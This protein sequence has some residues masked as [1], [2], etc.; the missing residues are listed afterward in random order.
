MSA[1]RTLVGTLLALALLGGCAAVEQALEA[2]KP[3]ASIAGMR[4]VAVDF[5]QAEV[6][7][8]VSIDNP[9]PVGIDLAGFDYALA[10]DGR[11]F[12]SGR[13][14]RALSLPADD[15]TTI[16]VP[17]TIP[18]A[19]I[20]EVVGELRGRD[21]VDYGLELGLDV[22]LPALGERRVRSSTSGSLPIPQRPRVSVAGARVDSLGLSGARLVL[23]LA[24]ANPNSFG[25]DLDR[26][27]YALA[28]NG[29]RWASGEHR[30]GVALP[31]NG[32]GN[33]SLPLSVRFSAIGAG[34][35]DLLAGGGEV[36]YTLNADVA[37]RSDLEGFAAFEMPIEQSGRLDL[38][39]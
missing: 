35:Y 26:L 23:D 33:V 8:D 18:F 13:R 10:L 5:E 4:L 20:G 19:R 28:I 21:R 3:T 6:E 30:A 15:S 39:R 2:R 31:A 36:D 7:F 37:G 1:A 16:A 24:V 38:A 29:R 14:D 12:L 27:D 17:L 32:T 25:V 34:A 11:E 9:N 22:D